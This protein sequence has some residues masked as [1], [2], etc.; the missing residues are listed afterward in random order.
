LGRRTGTLGEG[1]LDRPT[2]LAFDFLGN[3]AVVS[4]GS[5]EIAVFTPRGRLILKAPV[6]AALALGLAFEPRGRRALLTDARTGGVWLTQDGRSWSLRQ[7]E[8]LDRPL[9]VD[10]TGGRFLVVGSGD[11]HLVELDSGGEVV[12]RYRLNGASRAVGVTLPPFGNGAVV[13]S[14]GNH[15]GLF[16]ARLGQPF[17]RFGGARR[18]TAPTLPGSECTRV[19]FPDFVGNRVVAFDL[20]NAASCVQ[21][22]RLRRAVTARSLRRIT[23][24][25][26]AENDGSVKIGGRALVPSEGGRIKR[27]RLPAVTEP[28]VAAVGKE[29][30]LAIPAAAARALRGAL[31]RRDTAL[32]TLVFSVRNAAG[33][34]RRLT[35][36]LLYRPGVLG[37]LASA[38]GAASPVPVVVEP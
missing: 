30:R 35:G 17:V 34:R 12:E 32:V 5:R 14:A 7:P 33:D 37:R 3:L 13:S 4:A 1:V 38:S 15:S 18:M 25:A 26:V 22:L 2:G 28:V 19:A 23:L 27:Y 16:A 20:P 9:G 31:R 6:P 8:G 21:T 29:V 10:A 11:D 36:R 24:T